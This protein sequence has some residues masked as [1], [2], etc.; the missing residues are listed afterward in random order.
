[1]TLMRSGM[2]AASIARQLGVSRSTISRELKRTRHRHYD[3]QSAQANAQALRRKASTRAHAM[4]VDLRQ[5][6]L[7]KLSC[8]QWS[9][10]Q[11]SGWLARHNI[12]AISHEAIYQYIWADKR[13]G[14]TLYRQLRHHGKKYNK[15]KGHYTMRG[16]ISGRVDID[17][18]PSVVNEK[19]RIGD[20]PT[21][22]GFGGRSWEGDTIRSRNPHAA[23]LSHVE[24]RSKLVRLRKLTPATADEVMQATLHSFSEHKRKVLT[25]TYDNGKEFMQHRRIAKAL[26]AAVYFAK[27]YHAWERGLNEHTNGLVRQYFPKGTDFASVNPKKIAQVEKKLNKRP[28]KALDY[29]TPH[30][31]FYA[32]ITNT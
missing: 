26:K 9:P 3:A 24:R 12:G 32:T 27:P 18:R 28:R 20:P 7:R 21:P 22:R 6:I 17:Q 30:E 2:R 29:Q 15:R 13:S 23:L 14:G 11:I 16:G 4:T 10:E 25:I 31:V 1:M 8:Q 5:L 19:S